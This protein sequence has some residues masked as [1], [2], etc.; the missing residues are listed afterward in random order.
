[1][2]DL[3]PDT[4]L[5]MSEH[6]E[7]IRALGKHVIADVIEMGRRL[8]EVKALAV[9]GHWLPWLEREF[10]WTDQTARNFMMV[11]DRSKSKNFLNLDLP[12]SA[13]YLLAA[14]S[15]PIEA[16]DAV[17][18]QAGGGAKL[19]GA[20]V[21][22]IVRE[23][24]S[25]ANGGPCAKRE[26][27]ASSLLEH[28]QPTARA[29]SIHPSNRN[30]ECLQGLPDNVAARIDACQE[31]LDQTSS[32]VERGLLMAESKDLYKLL[33]RLYPDGYQEKI[34]FVIEN[35]LDVTMED[36]RTIGEALF[37]S[38]QVTMNAPHMKGYER[39]TVEIVRVKLTHTYKKEDI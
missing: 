28:D 10:G 2:Q 27:P 6:A 12:I 15:T 3:S 17:I 13:L 14:P 8:T 29:S 9:H 39:H 4:Q 19:S 25:S 37:E 20:E 5:L 38:W 31:R 16:I 30:A 36:G 35:I 21:K 23:A 24:K 18:E 34:D 32:A 11:F 22:K 7:A 1:M 26:A 33:N